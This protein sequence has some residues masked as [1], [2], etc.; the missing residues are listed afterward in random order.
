MKAKLV[1]FVLMPLLACADFVS[2][3]SREWMKEAIASSGNFKQVKKRDLSLAMQQIGSYCTWFSIKNN[4]VSIKLESPN[5]RVARHRRDSFINMLFDL[6][7]KVRLPDVEFVAEFGDLFTDKVPE[8]VPIF[9][10]CRK[11]SQKG[12]LVPDSEFT[13][14]S[15]DQA[16][17]ESIGA[18][19][20]WDL[21]IP[22]LVWRGTTTG[23]DWTVKTITNAPRYKLV[24]V[25]AS[26]TATMDVYFNNCCQKDKELESFLINKCFIKGWM[27]V[28]D[29]AKYRYQIL[30]DGNSATWCRT[31][32]QL[33]SQALI[34]KQKS[35]WLLP[36]HFGM[37][38]GVH[39][40]EVA[41]D[42]SNVFEKL[43]WAIANPEEAQSI[44]QNAFE[45]AKD[46]ITYNNLLAYV[47]IALQEYRQYWRG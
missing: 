45:F 25:G 44:A 20:P 18:A 8:G 16:K 23:D 13:K 37:K 3:Y 46:N 43:Q 10:Y 4:V 29:Q 21:K 32:W 33:F 12:I 30:V 35:D 19:A 11:A 22:R 14:W 7:K 31:Y 38:P 15:R 34:F 39:Y 40:I 42:L 27:S 28:E 36:V 26:N 1:F 6:S 47:Y 2:Q 24:E 9:C 17:A 5:I 41:N